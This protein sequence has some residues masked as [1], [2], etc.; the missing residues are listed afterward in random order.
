MLNEESAKSVAKIDLRAKQFRLLLHSVYELRQALADDDKQEEGEE[1][2]N[3]ETG[4]AGMHVMYT[5]SSFFQLILS[6]F[7]I[8]FN[9]H[10]DDLYL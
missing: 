2:K 1:D 10:P 7:N 8:G 5:C 3:D 9:R 6:V 4:V